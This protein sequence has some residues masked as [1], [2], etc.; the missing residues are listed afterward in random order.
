MQIKG[1]LTFYSKKGI[2][3]QNGTLLTKS[4]LIIACKPKEKFI[5]A[6]PTPESNSIS[7]GTDGKK[8][9]GSPEDGPP[10]KGL[11]H[12]TIQEQMH[13]WKNYR[14]LNIKFSVHKGTGQFPGD[15]IS[16]T[17]TLGQH[18][19]ESFLTIPEI[20]EL[21]FNL[22]HLVEDPENDL[23][24]GFS[25]ST[26]AAGRETMIYLVHGS[27]TENSEAPSG[28][29]EPHTGNSE[30][31]GDSEVSWVAFRVEGKPA[32]KGA[33]KRDGPLWSL[34]GR[35]FYFCGSFA[36]LSRSFFSA[37]HFFSSFLCNAKKFYVSEN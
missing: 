31:V 1:N 33:K 19:E 6:Q 3:V 11:E 26:W 12:K 35:V 10:K 15:I 20:R 14:F 2:L 30:S 25:T 28:T 27:R 22:Q 7:S 17:T 8:K 4:E 34:E 37:G 13:W 32:R 36:F 5:G 21:I 16:D 18:V 29:T 23:Q 24:W 9:S